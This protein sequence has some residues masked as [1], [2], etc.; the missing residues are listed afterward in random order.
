MRPVAILI[1]CSILPASAQVQWGSVHGAVI[2]PSGA[3]I[4]S[5]YV[6]V[7]SNTLPRGI[8]TQTDARGGYLLPALP[9][10]SY[11][12]TVAAPG[13]HTLLYHNLEIRLGVQL[14]FNAR[15][16]LG[17]VSESIEVNDPALPADVA[18]PKPPPRSR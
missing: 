5:A 16:S 9:V 18:L 3:A 10:G 1:C 14:T 17:S 8:S 11:T 12:V 2:D 7:T 4:P 13:F 6:G 15:M